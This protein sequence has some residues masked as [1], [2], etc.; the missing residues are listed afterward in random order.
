MTNFNDRYRCT[1]IRGKA[2]SLIEDLVPIYCNIISKYDG[3]GHDYFT[4][5]FH[6]EM[7]VILP[8]TDNE[9]NKS[10][11]ERYKARKKTIDN[12]RSEI[13]HK[14]YGLYYVD[15]NDNVHLSKRAKG[16]LE[17]G[18]LT[19]LFKS[20]VDLFQQPNG[21]EKSK[22]VNEKLKHQIRLKPYHFIMILLVEA[23]KSNIVLTKNEVS[24]YVLDSLSVLQGKVLPK[25][26]LRQIISD[27][28]NKL[29]KKICYF[30]D[31]GKAKP[32]SFCYQHTN[33]QLN[34]L[35]LTG[36]IVISDNFI[37]L[38]ENERE[39]IEHLI[40]QDPCELN[41][42][43]DEYSTKLEK[44]WD[45][46]YNAEVLSQI[47]NM[48][49]PNEIDH[50]VETPVKT[51][52]STVD[53]GDIG[54]ELVYKFETERIR[55]F[56]KRLTNKVLKMGKQRGLGYDIQSIW[57]IEY[58]DKQPDATY[59]IEVKTTKRITKPSSMTHDKFTLT[60]NEWLSAD[61]HKENFAIFRVYLTRD[62]ILVQK[63]FDPLNSGSAFCVPVNYNY[64]FEITEELE[65]WA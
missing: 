47:D 32:S 10:E 16:F 28:N 35:E 7:N 57:G 18:D 15:A 55:K 30:D 13:S 39:F 17:D 29:E 41:F 31:K 49:V 62:E 2:K 50:T 11:I 52:L 43:I 25:V 5:K 6:N 33:E 21:M 12:H 44:Q 51:K 26:V 14:L 38:N 36:A 65:S 37:H 64:E 40:D 1:I 34:M 46:Y 8:L 56:N 54:E 20:L 22:K 60:R 53:I 24:Y 63:I 48:T 9:M 45:L 42:Q 61:Q 3:V 27:R 19:K 59:Y 58:S 4:E 23:K